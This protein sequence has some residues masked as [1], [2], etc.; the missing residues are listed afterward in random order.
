[1]NPKPA[2][3]VIDMLNEFVTGEL[4][5]E[6][7][8]NV[9]PN[10]QRLL[11]AARQA[12]IP[13]IY[14]NDAHLPSDPEI[15][16]WGEHAMA[17]TP[18]AEVIPEL[19]PQEGDHQVPSRTYSAFHDTD[20][21]SLLQSLDVDSVIFTGIHTHICVQHSAGDAFFRGYRIE[22]VDDC[23]DAFTH[24]EHQRGLAYVEEMYGAKLVHT[25]ELLARFSQ[26][27]A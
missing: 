27:V 8:A 13:I 11:A 17:G 12:G 20:M 9:I 3:L 5:F 10:L 1:M 24:E 22:V 19:A 21:D 7:T 26:R 4:A 6:M 14:A 23:V 18:G 16:I 15:A 2:I 25:D